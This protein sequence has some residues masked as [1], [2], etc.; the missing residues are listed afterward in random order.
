MI[1][2]LNCFI[3]SFPFLILSGFYGACRLDK[4][5]ARKPRGQHKKDLK[6]NDDLNSE[7][8]QD[9]LF[10]ERIRL[11]KMDL[12]LCDVL[13]KKS[14]SLSLS[15]SSTLMNRSLRKVKLNDQYLGV[16]YIFSASCLFLISLLT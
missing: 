2:N 16:Y 1:G 10:V 3:H 14:L 4:I 7:E 13:L 6:K 11:E 5:F 12:R 9:D 15:L 8:D